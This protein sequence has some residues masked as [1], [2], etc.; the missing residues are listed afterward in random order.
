MTQRERVTNI[1]DNKNLRRGSWALQTS[2]ARK[3]GGDSERVPEGAAGRRVKCSLKVSQG[4]I[5][6][7]GEV[8]L[9]QRSWWVE[10]GKN[11]ALTGNAN[12]KAISGLDRISCSGHRKFK[13]FVAYVGREYKESGERTQTTPRKSFSIKDWGC[14]WKGLMGK[15]YQ[16]CMMQLIRRENNRRWTEVC[17]R[18]HQQ[19]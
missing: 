6:R 12:V 19:Q 2:E 11:G 18:F 8:S 7:E 1:N 16:I 3:K 10:F 13:A 15:L 4:G 14:G 9:L 5:S 17:G